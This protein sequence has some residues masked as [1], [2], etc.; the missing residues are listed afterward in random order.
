VNGTVTLQLERYIVDLIIWI[1]DG[2]PI[3]LPSN[4]EGKSPISVRI[5]EGPHVLIIEQQWGD[6]TGIRE[7]P[8]SVPH[9]RY[10]EV[11]LSGH[12]SPYYL[13]TASINRSPIV[14]HPKRTMFRGLVVAGRHSYLFQEDRRRYGNPRLSGITR[15]EIPI[16][17]ERRSVEN[18]TAGK[19][20]RTVTI[21][22]DWSRS[23]SIEERTV[24]TT[25]VALS[26][27]KTVNLKT[28]AKR[29]VSKAYNISESSAEH[30]SDNLKVEV[31]PFTTIHIILKWKQLWER[32]TISFTE[33]SGKGETIT[34]PFSVLVDVIYDAEL[35][36]GK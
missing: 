14:I 35:A 6:Y 3:L 13:F 8:K 10:D 22:K 9:Q 33:L 20:E 24:T 7:L 36:L 26:Y 16:G 4:V 17:S 32:G 19:V 11:G 5:S 34:M 2:P 1:D 18:P 23:V 28:D 29:E 15:D 12:C 27:G 21:S 31:P 30:I 25:S